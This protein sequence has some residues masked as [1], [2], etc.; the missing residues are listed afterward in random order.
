[1][2]IRL[3]SLVW[4]YNKGEGFARFS[5]EFFK[6]H[7]VVQLDALSDCIAELEAAYNSLLSLPHDQAI[8]RNA[9]KEAL[10]K[11]RDEE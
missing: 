5:P 4:D 3:V 8:R 1:M 10:A 9:V 7:P 6:S 11:A 2:S